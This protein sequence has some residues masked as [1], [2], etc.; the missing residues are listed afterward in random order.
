MEVAINDSSDIIRYFKEPV[1]KYDTT[2][3]RRIRKSCGISQSMFANC[4]GVSKK[5]VEAWE[6]GKNTPNGPAC[7][8]LYMLDNK[9]LALPFVNMA[10]GKV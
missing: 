6:Y 4:M 2:E 10:E 3:I 8:L 7:R 5:T 1:K 9:R